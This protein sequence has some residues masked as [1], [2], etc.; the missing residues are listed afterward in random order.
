MEPLVLYLGRGVGPPAL[1][2]FVPWYPHSLGLANCQAAAHT[3]TL[4]SS[5]LS[6]VSQQHVRVASGR[7]VGGKYNENFTIQ[8]PCLGQMH[9]PRLSTEDACH[10]LQELSCRPAS[11]S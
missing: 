8:I 1:L 10:L 3:G 7:V 4:M 2:F 9:E 11:D 5:H 6:R